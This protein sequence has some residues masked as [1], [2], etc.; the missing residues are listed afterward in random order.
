MHALLALLLAGAPVV[1]AGAAPAPAS[2]SPVAW[3]EG[4][5]A[6]T[7]Y[8]SPVELAEL[9]P[10][11]AGAAALRAADPGAKVAVARPTVRVW[12]VGDATAVRAK[13]PAEVARRVVAVLRDGP[14]DAAKLRVAAGDVVVVLQAGLSAEARAA[15]SRVHGATVRGQAFLVPAAPGQPSLDLAARLAAEPQVALATPNWWLAARTR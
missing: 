12:T 1:T 10:D 13:L 6:R 15:W 9:S 3:K 2:W 5:A 11:D 4:A 14:T 8:L 7:S